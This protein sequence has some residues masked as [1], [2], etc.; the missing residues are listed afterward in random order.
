[1]SVVVGIIHYYTCY[2]MNTCAISMQRVDLGT[3]D[4]LPVV[5][6]YPPPPQT[7]MRQVGDTLD[8]CF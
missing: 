3:L 1:M 8:S 4:T 2:L 5:S 7:T 6:F